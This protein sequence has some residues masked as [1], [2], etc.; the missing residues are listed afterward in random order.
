MRDRTP[1]VWEEKTRAAGYD[2]SV[3]ISIAGIGR[4]QTSPQS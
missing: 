2:P 1:V 4:M 3:V